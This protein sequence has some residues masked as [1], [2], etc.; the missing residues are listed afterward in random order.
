M[1]PKAK[2]KELVDKFVGFELNPYDDIEMRPKLL[3]A[4]KKCVNCG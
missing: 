3:E 4:K 1:T 2:A